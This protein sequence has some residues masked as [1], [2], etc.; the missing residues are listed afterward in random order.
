MQTK[1][2]KLSFLFKILTTIS[3]VIFVSFILILSVRGQFGVPNSEEINQNYWKEAGPFELSPERGRFALLYSLVEDKSFDFSLP[4]AKFATPDLGYINGKYVSLFAPGLS[5]VLIPGYLLGKLYGASQVGTYFMVAI[6]ALFNVLLIRSILQ[7]LKVSSIAA[8]LS[9]LT[10]L[11]ATPAFAYSVSLYQHHLSTFII[12]LALYFL[13]KFKSAWSLLF[14]WFLCA[15]SIPID[16]PNLF[17]MLPIGVAALGKIISWQTIKENVVVSFKPLAMF[18][19][20]SAFIPLA[21]FLWF[22]TQSYGNPLQFSGTVT[23]VKSINAE[24]L[25]ENNKITETTP[26]SE[27]V[28]IQEKRSAVAFFDTRNMLNGLNTHL[29]SVDRG[30]LLFTPVILL[31]I[32]GM[33]YLYKS[34][35]SATH[36]LLGIIVLCIVLYSMWGDPYG[37]W[38]FGSRYLIPAYAILAIFLGVALEKL[39]KNI[40]FLLLFLVL[41]GYST[42][43]N[44]L[45]AITTSSI[46]PKVEVLFLESLSGK[47]EKY[48]YWK[49]YDMIEAGY[50]KSFVFNASVKQYFTAKEY[51]YFI[52]GSIFSV[53]FVLT[54]LFYLRK[55]YV[56]T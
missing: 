6:F 37:G 55:K 32:F 47:E 44:T 10:F 11:F 41:F 33:F 19:V 54:I 26:E 8:I 5:F 30:V 3:F 34:N 35:P 53:V 27:L 22:N 46:P 39:R 17:F 25:P 24:G 20:I 42:A 49:S 43:V 28:Q 14:I 31:S 9:A 36:V 18:T 15:A 12:L 38:A 1:K 16:Y 45:G 13:F 51:Y 29:F 48:N 56:I 23:A 50:S 52:S 4:V 2:S 40:L 21:F 7:H